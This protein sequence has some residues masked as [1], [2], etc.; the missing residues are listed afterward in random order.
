MPHEN[1]STSTTL[2]MPLERTQL[3]DVFFVDIVATR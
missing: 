3:Q 2:A 1:M